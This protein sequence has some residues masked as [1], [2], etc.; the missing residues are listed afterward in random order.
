MSEKYAVETA[1]DH[2]DTTVP[3]R[4]SVSSDGHGNQQDHLRHVPSYSREG[5]EM[6]STYWRSPRFLGSIL[7]IALL[8]NS[9]FIGYA[10]PIN[11]L[12]VIDADI[13]PSPN[14]YLASLTF[15]LVSGVLLLI[16]GSL[17]DIMGRRWFIIVAQM[18]GL[19]GSVVCATAKNVNTLVAGTVLTAV[20]G[21]A[22]QLYPL[23]V[24]ELVPNKYRVWAQAFI[25]ATVVPTIGFGTLFARAFVANTA[26]AWRWCYWL[27]VIVCGISILLFAFCYFPPDFQTINKNMTRMEELKR[28]DYG[29]LILY[30]AGLVLLLL[31]F[32]WGEGTYPWNS[33]HT[34][35]TIIVGAVLVAI[36][37]IYEIY[38]PL[39]QPLVPI[40]IFKIRNVNAAMV[41][42]CVAQMV[43]Y[44]MNLLYPMMITT[45]FTTDNIKIGL[46]SS[47]T[48]TS[49][50]V[51]EILVAPLFK[52]IG[53][54]RYQLIAASVII[55]LSTALMCL[56]DGPSKLGAA[57]ALTLIAGCC[58]GVIEAVCI[59]IVGLVVNPDD[60]GVAMGFFASV[61]AITGTIA[62][63][64]YVSVYSARLPVYLG[65]EVPK[66][67]EAAGL[68]VSSVTDLMTAF[69]N[70]TTAA[71]ESVPGM[72]SDILTAVSEGSLAGYH[73]TFKVVFLATLAFGALSIIAA[74]FIQEI[75]H[76]L[77]NFINKTLTNTS[78]RT[79][80]EK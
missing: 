6:D 37:I 45:F 35:S 50:A 51:G 27:N 48:G 11:V 3:N 22:Q 20:A 9:L 24:Q 78:R 43:Y 47:T 67:A 31:G 73:D 15:T 57:I 61:R 38:M 16:I 66:Y 54:L 41:I 5:E 13:G 4:Q 74:F 28:I 76:L 1:T 64:I 42:G 40:R 14:I 25:M 36:F 68:P 80:V 23:L 59:T 26:L 58:V 12:G 21:A 77:N 2:I 79:D 29:G 55:S 60:I 33:A 34:L 63:S 32:T 52:R 7:A 10:M 19:V 65:R 39:S 72:T 17:S 44:A 18:F 46:M 49:L 71:L 70:G 56:V 53:H 69:A 75:G 30:S 8:A 62:L